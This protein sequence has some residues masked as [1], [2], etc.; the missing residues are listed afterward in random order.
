MLRK[1]LTF[2][3]QAFLGTVSFFFCIS[4]KLS[5]LFQVTGYEGASNTSVSS[6]TRE[7]SVMLWKCHLLSH[8][9]PP[10]GVVWGSC[11][12]VKSRGRAGEG[13]LRSVEDP[14]PR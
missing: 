6:A 1:S 13:E 14:R 3:D 7:R 12:K 9:K 4:E 5:Y 10:S 2:G 8:K 11:F